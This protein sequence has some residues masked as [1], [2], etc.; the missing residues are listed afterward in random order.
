MMHGEKRKKL[1][2]FIR[3]LSTA[4][5]FFFFIFACLVK[6]RD[7]RYDDAGITVGIRGR[8]R[9]MFFRRAAARRC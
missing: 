7:V 2:V 1:Q 3:N 6:N 8:R 9:T 4:N 5:I